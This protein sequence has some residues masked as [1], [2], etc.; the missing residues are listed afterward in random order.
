MNRAIVAMNIS[1]V[2]DDEQSH[3]E[4]IQKHNDDEDENYYYDATNVTFLKRFT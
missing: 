4:H 2:E 3:F 1:N